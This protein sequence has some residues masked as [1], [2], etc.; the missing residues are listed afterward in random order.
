MSSVLCC[1]SRGRLL[2]F[3]YIRALT[4]IYAAVCSVRVSELWPIIKITLMSNQVCSAI[5]D[6][7]ITCLLENYT[8]AQNALVV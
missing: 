8:S 4:V 2:I 7:V 5:E 1:S 6:L 3:C